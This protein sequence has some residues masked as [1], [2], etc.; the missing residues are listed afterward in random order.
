M[1]VQE[2]LFISIALDVVVVY[3]IYIH[4]SNIVVAVVDDIGNF[5]EDWREYKGG[6]C[7]RFSY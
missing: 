7:G 5:I 1:N 2:L 4:W 6:S 3:S